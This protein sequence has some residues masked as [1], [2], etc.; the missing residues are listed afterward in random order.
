[1]IESRYTLALN[2]IKDICKKDKDIKF[3]NL[4]SFKNNVNQ[5]KY[6]IYK[7]INPK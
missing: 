2:I 7:V 1:M 6:F 5:S 3:I 4:R